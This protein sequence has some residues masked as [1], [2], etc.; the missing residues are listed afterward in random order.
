MIM[1]FNWPKFEAF[2]IFCE[3][4]IRAIF[5]FYDI[6]SQNHLISR[7]DAITGIGEVGT[8]GC[9]LKTVNT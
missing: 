2:C 8:V 1:P 9:T 3:Y 7:H 4:N 6:C 5:C